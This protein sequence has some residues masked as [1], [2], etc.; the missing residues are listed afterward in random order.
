M[1]VCIVKNVIFLRL[2]QIRGIGVLNGMLR[3]NGT[4]LP[5]LSQENGNE[6]DPYI[7]WTFSLLNIGSIVR[8]D[9]TAVCFVYRLM[10]GTVLYVT[11]AIELHVD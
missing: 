8:I 5:A 11:S 2:G 9:Y 10:N 3:D 1:F 6:W 4:E 7:W